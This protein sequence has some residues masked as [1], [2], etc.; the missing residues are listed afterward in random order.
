MM[1]MTM[2]DMPYN[3]IKPKPYIPFSVMYDLMIMICSQRKSKKRYFRA[4][5]RKVELISDVI[6]WTLSHGRAKVGRPA[7]T[8][9]QQLST[10][11][12]W[13]TY[14]ERWTIEAG[15]ERGSADL[16]WQSDMMMMMTILV[17]VLT[18]ERNLIQQK[19]IQ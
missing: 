11:V 13:K 14:Q 3:H 7:R 6:L 1:M 2:V 4:R 8:Y 9:L 10:N 16:C 17:S 12:A 19:L 15:G 5:F 18:Y